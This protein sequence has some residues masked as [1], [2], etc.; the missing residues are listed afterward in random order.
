MSLVPAHRLLDVQSVN[1]PAC[2][3]VCCINAT[4]NGGLAAED[5]ALKQPFW[6]PLSVVALDKRQLPGGG[7]VGSLRSLRLGVSSSLSLRCAL[8]V[9]SL[10]NP[11][12]SL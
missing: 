2:C 11:D 7:M 9:L 1:H 5:E 10:T 12:E 3:L 6:Q 4:R 8:Y